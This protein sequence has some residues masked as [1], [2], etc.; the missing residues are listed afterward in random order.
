[1]LSIAG[2]GLSS[3]LILGTGGANSLAVLERAILASGTELVTVA[4]RRVESSEHGLLEMLERLGV[5]LLPNTAGCYTAHDAVRTARL[6][7]EAF[8]T[9]WVKLEVIGDERTLLPDAVEL[10]RAA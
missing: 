8:E 10:V 5:R 7:R 1:M 9:D 6:A 4:L 2:V 3:R